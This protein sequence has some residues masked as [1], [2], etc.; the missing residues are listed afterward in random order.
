MTEIIGVRFKDIGKVY[1]FD[2]Q[3]KTAEAGQMV[4]VETARGLELGECTVGNKMVEDNEIVSPLKP[5]IRI[6]TDED[7]RIAEQTKKKEKE[8]DGSGKGVK[9]YAT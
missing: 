9:D 4:I 5:L 8:A 6:A 2:P 7:L 3:G 1:Y